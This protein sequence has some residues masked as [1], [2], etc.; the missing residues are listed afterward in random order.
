MNQ[1]RERFISEEDDE[2][3]HDQRSKFEKNGEK[4]WDAFET[5]SHN[6]FKLQQGSQRASVSFN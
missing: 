5:S 4:T 1:K 2:L 6:G 3:K